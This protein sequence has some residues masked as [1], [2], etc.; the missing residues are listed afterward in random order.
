MTAVS[1]S[2][3]KSIQP[4]AELYVTCS[5]CLFNFSFAS[6]Q[7]SENVWDVNVLISW[8]RVTVPGS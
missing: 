1:I 8:I 6:K 3:D 7:F 2:P 4:E 5:H